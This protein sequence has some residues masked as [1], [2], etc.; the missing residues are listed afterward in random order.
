V[1]LAFD[2]L[3]TAGVVTGVLGVWLTVRQKLWC[4]PVSLVNVSLYAIIFFRARLYADV[5][6][7]A[8]FFVLCAL[9][10]WR[11]LHP[12][13]AREELPVSRITAREGATL[14]ALGL[15][16]ALGM[17]HFFATHTDAALPYWDSTTVA[18]SLVAQWLLTRK[19]LENWQL[20][21]VADVMMVGIYLAK[22]LTPTAGLYALYTLLAVQ[23]LREWR[24]S[25][26]TA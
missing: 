2:P 10:W 12:G 5:G 14:A 13:L 24:R 18:M 20:W 9:G 6:L 8:V 17:G 4:W 7:Q 22:G 25:M 15:V 21:I 16:A 11:W 26:L 3:E 23:G 1:P 19:I